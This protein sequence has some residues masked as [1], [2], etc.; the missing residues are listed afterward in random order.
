VTACCTAGESTGRTMRARLA[1]LLVLG[2]SAEA[3]IDWHWPSVSLSARLGELGLEASGLLKQ[4]QHAPDA[5]QVE[6]R[7]RE[8]RDLPKPVDVA[9]TVATGAAFTADGF[10]EALSFVC[11]EG[12]RMKPT[13]LRCDRDAEQST[14]WFSPSGSHGHHTVESSST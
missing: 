1:S 8:L 2:V 3:A 5:D 7:R 13:Q 14:L 4:F 6:P 12:L 11:A 10:E 9:G